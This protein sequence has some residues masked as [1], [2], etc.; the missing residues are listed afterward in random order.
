MS[1]PPARS[2]ALTRPDLNLLFTLDVLLAEGNV[3]RAAR[4]LRLS[5]SAMSRSLARLRD[6]TGDPLLVRAGRALV[7]SPRALELRESHR[8]S[9]F[10]TPKPPCAPPTGSISDDSSEP[11]PCGPAK[12]SSRTSAPRSWRA[13]PT[14]APGVACT[15]CTS[16]TRTAGRCATAPSIWKPAWST[17]RSARK[18]ARRHCSATATSA[19][20]ERGTRS[21]K[22]RSHRSRFAAAAHVHVS[23]RDDDNGPIDERPGRVR[24]GAADCGHRRRFLGG[25]CIGSRHRSGRDR[26]RA[27]HGQSVRRHAQLRYSLWP[28]RN[29]PFHCSGTRGWTVTPRTAGCAVVFAKSAEPCRSRTTRRSRRWPCGIR[30][31][32][33]EA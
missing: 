15:S 3:A 14:E 30:R 32:A 17:R 33:E 31:C 28:F 21:A 2:N 8:A 16:S 24:A 13:W 11:S 9:S 29:S 7:A 19:S 27:A 22:A 23:R 4:R 25:T 20:C 5:P 18:C 10:K 12:V 1:G 6:A 26:P